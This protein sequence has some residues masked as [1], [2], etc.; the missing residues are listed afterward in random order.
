LAP[1]LR[2]QQRLIGIDF[3]VD[4]AIATHAASGA[5]TALPSA[6]PSGAPSRPSRSWEMSTVDE[7]PSAMEAHRLPS[8][9]TGRLDIIDP[10]TIRRFGSQ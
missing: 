2:W 1:W 10:A 9:T 8:P 4:A 3:D 6:A 5:A 7:L